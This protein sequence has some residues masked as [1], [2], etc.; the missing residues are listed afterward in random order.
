MAHAKCVACRVRV[1]A[2]AAAAV[3]PSCGG[4]LEAVERA[5]DLIGLQAPTSDGS[6]L[7]DQVRATIAR[8][9]AARVRRL[10]RS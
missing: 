4:A 1:R 7:A 3:C 10:R 6:S 2:D 5:D 9:E 8:N